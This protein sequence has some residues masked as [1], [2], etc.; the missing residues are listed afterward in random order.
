MKSNITEDFE[1]MAANRINQALNAQLSPDDLTA[2]EQDVFFELFT[3]EMIQASD[4]MSE[5][6]FDQVLKSQ[7]EHIAGEDESGNI[8]IKKL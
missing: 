3:E 6:D 4:A 8:V 1:C 5:A 2:D 7:G